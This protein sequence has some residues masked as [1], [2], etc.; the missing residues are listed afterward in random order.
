MLAGP[1]GR[2]ADEKYLMSNYG[3]TNHSVTISGGNQ[4]H[5]F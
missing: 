1:D 3:H 5:T 4:N 2:K